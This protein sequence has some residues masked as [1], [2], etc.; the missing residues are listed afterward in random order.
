VSDLC[1]PGLADESSARATADD[2]TT[3]PQPPVP[4][5]ASRTDGSGGHTAPAA[6]GAPQ[7]VTGESD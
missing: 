2:E 4:D 3:P 1:G 5:K 7:P 6:G